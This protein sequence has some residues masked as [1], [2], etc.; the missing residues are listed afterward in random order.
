[1]ARL[2]DSQLANHYRKRLA[3]ETRL[4]KQC[5]EQH[6]FAEQKP[7]IG[8]E[9]EFFLVDQQGALVPRA[10]EFLASF[11]HNYAVPEV[12]RAVVEINS[13][14]YQVKKNILEKSYATLNQCWQAA[15]QH[16]SAMGL[17]AVAVGIL[18]SSQPNEFA[19]SSLISNVS[20]YQLLNKKLFNLRGAIPVNINI[21]GQQELNFSVPTIAYCGLIC[22][23]HFHL[24]VP[25]S[26]SVRFYNATQI[27]SAPLIALS[28]NS[29]FLFGKT[30]WE[31]TRINLGEKLFVGMVNEN[32]T[33]DSRL[34]F[35]NE[36]I[37]SIYDLFNENIAYAS[38][39]TDTKEVA[40]DKFW[41]VRRLNGTIY[42]WN[43]PVIG[44]DKTGLPHL[45]IEIRVMPAGPTITDTI[46]N[47]A[48]FLGLLQ[49]LG[50]QKQSP[51]KLLPF[52]SIKNNFYKAARYGLMARL[53]WFNHKHITAQQLILQEL[54]PIAEQ[55]LSALHIDT[56][57]IHYY[58]DI[59]QQR[60][61]LNLTGSQWLQKTM[62]QYGY[63][64]N[65]LVLQ[66][67]HCQQQ[68][69]PVHEWPI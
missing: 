21:K 39:L 56:N 37:H 17:K 34:N 62:N 25:M 35:G 58:L 61:A 8:F 46:A 16:A 54:L 43:R 44:F 4:L 66:Y 48:F 12:H 24:Q 23:T 1:M 10:E 42:R 19:E 36:Y 41:H 55:G 52:T 63:S 69:K 13:N 7:R 14:H 68:E 40:I 51:E 49:V 57:A 9:L 29:P 38:A 28:A 45:Q 26:C 33:K 15:Q 65:E 53:E 47:V 59:I 3:L 64:F 32:N 30:L 5:F 22:G 20:R 11:Q 31:E 60:V 27:I 6:Y 2:S 67:Q 18:P 50:T